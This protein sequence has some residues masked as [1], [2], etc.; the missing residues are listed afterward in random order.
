MS[1]WNNG[2][3]ADHVVVI[4]GAGAGIGRAISEVFVRAGAAVVLADRDAEATASVAKELQAHGAAALDQPTDV[5]HPDQVARLV[6]ASVDTFGRI[7]I[8]VN[9]A[10]IIQ[11]GGLLEVGLDDWRRVF[12]VNVEGALLTLQHALPVML[13]QQPHPTSGCRGKVINVSSAAAEHGRPILP[14][15]GASKAALNHLSKTAAATWAEQLIAT[16]V[17]YPGNVKEGMWRDLAPQIAAAEQREVTE[18][19][20]ERWF[21]GP[22]EVA[23]AAL[24]IAASRGMGLNSQIVSS[25]PQ[26]TQL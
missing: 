18:V 3:L 26:V 7:D 23:N 1:N 21:Q 12:A 14:A 16:T 11:I 22:E 19:L 4:T 20:S 25:T 15:Y 17:L 2:L 5:T 6:K 9:N 24:F 8:L 13:A 10:G